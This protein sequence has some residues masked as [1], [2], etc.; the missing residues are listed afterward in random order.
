MPMSKANG[1]LR[2][3]KNPNRPNCETSCFVVPPSEKPEVDSSAVVNPTPSQALA[4]EPYVQATDA[5]DNTVASTAKT[6]LGTAILAYSAGMSITVTFYHNLNN[7]AT[8]RSFF[9]DLSF[10]QDN[11][12]VAYLKI[13]NFQMKLKD[14]LA[15]SYDGSK[16]KSQ[17]TGEAV[18]YPFFVPWTG[19][20]FIYEV[21]KGVYGLYKITDPPTRLSIKDLTGH[22]IKFILVDY[23]SKEQLD[24]MNE[25]V[26]EERYFNLQR[27]ISG[28][29]ALLTSD[30]TE[31]LGQVKEAI[32]KLSKYY[33]SEFYEKYIYRT[34]IENPCLYDP[35]IVEFIT[36]VFDYKYFRAYPTQLVPS[37]E[38]W[39]RSFWAR[40]LD[41]DTVPKEVV[42]NKCYRILK[43]VH[44]R[45]AGINALTNRCYIR[46]HPNGRHNY[47]PFNIPT[48]YD[49]E[50]RTIQMQILLY[51]S[52]G[53]VRP[54]VLLELVDKILTCKRLA[55]FYF[56]P[57]LVFLLKKLQGILETGSGG[58]IM[59]EPTNDACDMDCSTCVY[60]CDCD[61]KPPMP[62]TGPP[63]G[64]SGCCPCHKPGPPMPVPPHHPGPPWT[65]GLEDCDRYCIPDDGGRAQD[66]YGKPPE[67]A[68]DCGESY[69]GLPPEER[70][71]AQKLG[72]N[73]FET[74][75][76]W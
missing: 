9:N 36:R 1:T 48:E 41:P 10:Q 21:Q 12:H 43:G 45:T 40:L 67:I 52:E 57:I 15:F 75:D 38:W 72:Y 8:A 49:A 34:F 76:G 69:E 74:A 54:K 50:T 25:R 35:Y 44:Y 23:L 29:G 30:E 46:L 65:D 27:Y 2:K 63:P 62:P 53:K 47:P 28:E 7:D 4:S 24:K 16:V 3:P 13:N 66:D 32:T 19:D 22:E 56:I 59:E 39:S 20:L 70:A 73:P 11:V 6:A 58:I 37:P 71:L 18:L 60:C 42:I 61:R 17:V 68:G 5:A 33:V 14:S 31:T 55:R 26:V 64:G 51:L